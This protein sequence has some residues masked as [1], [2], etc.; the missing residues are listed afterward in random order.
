LYKQTNQPTNS[1]EAGGSGGGGGSSNDDDDDDDDD[2]EHPDFNGSSSTGGG[3]RRPCR[4]VERDAA[5]GGVRAHWLR[6]PESYDEWRALADV[7]AGA[8]EA[9]G[10]EVCVCVL[11]F[12]YVHLI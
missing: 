8:K 7:P 9:G 10:G 1:T 6:Y 4:I 3:S 5:R 2:G 12:I 11:I